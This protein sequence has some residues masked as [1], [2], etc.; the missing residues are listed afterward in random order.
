MVLWNTIHILANPYLLHYIEVLKESPLILEEINK[1]IM[2][3]SNPAISSGKIEKY[4]AINLEEF[5]NSRNTIIK[6]NDKL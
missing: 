3:I 4:F 6:F 2:K 1:A 5:N